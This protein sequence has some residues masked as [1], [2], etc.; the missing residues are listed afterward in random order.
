M[1]SVDESAVYIATTVQEEFWIAQILYP[2]A[3]NNVVAYI[4]IDTDVDID[5][6]G[7]ALRRVAAES[8]TLNINFREA[9]DQLCVISRR[10]TEWSPETIDLRSRTDAVAAA[11]RYLDDERTRLFDLQKD[12]LYR[13]TL[14]RIDTTRHFIALCFHHIVVDAA[15]L[16]LWVHRVFE[17]Y[18]SL[19]DGREI[20]PSGFVGI[21]EILDSRRRYEANEMAVDRDYWLAQV[22]G[23]HEFPGFPGTM[24]SGRL[25][26]TTHSMLLPVQSL[27]GVVELAD[28]WRVEPPFVLMAVTA[29]VLHR[30]SQQ[31]DLSLQVPLSNRRG[32]V[33]R[34]PCVVSTTVP[35]TVEVAGD[36]SL[37]SLTRDLRR[38]ILDAGRHARYGIAGI[39][40]DL[41]L[42]SHATNPFGPSVNV[43][44]LATSIPVGDG[45]ARLYPV[46]SGRSGEFSITFCY[47]PRSTSEM[48][49][50][51]EADAALYAR[52]DLITYTSLLRR[53]LD[54]VIG[55]PDVVVGALAVLDEA[56]RQLV[57]E[58]RTNTPEHPS[59]GPSTVDLIEHWSTAS[60]DSVAISFDSGSITY[61]EMAAR[62]D[63]LART[64]IGHGVGP[65]DVVAVALT[66]SPELIIV[67]LA[68]M[69]AGGAYLPVDLSSPRERIEFML[70]DAGP[71]VIV[72]DATSALL[73]PAGFEG[74][75]MRVDHADPLD[76]G[77]GNPGR[78]TRTPASRP[79]HLA[80][81]IYTSGSTG[82]PK[83]VAIT[84]ADLIGLL[85][86]TS[87]WARFGPE[88]VWIWCH[89][90]AFDFSV[91]E[92]WGALAYGGRLVVAPWEAVRSPQDLRRLIAAE[93]VTILNQTPSAFYSL[94][95]SEPRFTDELAALRMVVFGGEAL[96]PGRVSKWLNSSAADHVTL[97]N[98]YG[99]TESTVHVTHRVITA[100]DLLDEASPIGQPLSGMTAY[101]L[102][103]ALRPMPIGIPGELYVAGRQLARGYLG[104]A[105]LTAARFVANPFDES[106]GARLYRTGDVVRWTSTGELDYLGRSDDQVKLRGYRIELGEIE[107][108]LLAHPA[109]VQ[110]AVDVHRS[111]VN[112]EPRLIGYVRLHRGVDTVGGV[113]LRRFVG[114]R[115]PEFMVPA[116]VMVLDAFPLTVNGKLDRR[117]LPDPGFESS[118]EYRA[119][120]GDR[121][122]LLADVFGEVLGVSGV[123][124]D[125]SF[126]ELGGHSLLAT[127]LV[128][129]IRSVFGVEV[130]LPVVFDGPTVAQLVTR[131]DEAGPVRPALVRTV[132]PG[133]VPLSFAQQRL[134]F[135]HRFEGP[136]ATYNMPVALRLSGSVDLVALRAA[137]V[138]VVERHEALR[139][140]FIEVDGVAEQRVVD[141][142]QV[143]VPFSVSDADDL[144]AACV[145][146]AQY[147]FDL[148]REIPLRASVFRCSVDEYVL[149]LVVHHIAGDGWSV[150]PFFGDLTSAYAA[151]VLGDVADRVPLPVQY[152]DYTLWQRQLLGSAG[153]EASVLSQQLDYWRRELAGLPEQIALPT[154]RPRPRVAS[155]R[156]D[157]VP[158]RI[159]AETRESIERLA[160]R[161]NATVSMVLQS[162]LVT[163]LH[164]LGAGDD[165]AIGS[166]IAGRTDEALDDLVGFFV[167]TWVLRARVTPDLSFTE[168]VSQVRTKSLAAYSN[169][170]APFEL[171]VE[172]LNP[173]RSS[174]HPLFQIS[175][176]FQNTTQ[177]TVTLPGTIVTELEIP[178]NTARF[179]LAF[180]LREEDTSEPD[181][182]N[183]RDHAG[184]AGYIEYSTDLFDRVTVETIAARFARTVRN[185]A[186][187]PTIAVAAVD[188]LDQ[189]E[190]DL[191]L[192]RW[193][194]T[195][196]DVDHDTL[197]ELFER[198]VSASPNAVALLGAET[199]LTYRELDTRTN[200]LAYTLLGLGVGPE[201]VVAVALPRSPE[202]IIALVGIL[203]AGAAYL[204][205]DL[206]YPAERLDYILTDAAPVVVVTDSATSTQIPRQSS[207]LLVDQLIGDEK[208]RNLEDA[209][210]AH[211]PT[212]AN[213]AYVIYTS[214]TTGMPKGTVVTH[215]A[216]ANVTKQ[217]WQIGPGDRVL[218]HCAIAFD[219]SAYEI[220]PTLI[221]GATLVPGPAG[222]FEPTAI[223]KLIDNQQITH[224]FATCSALAALLDADDG[225]Q[226]GSLKRIDTGTEVL[227]PTTVGALHSTYPQTQLYNLYG[228]TETTVAITE[229]AL[230]EDDT[231][232]S[233]P[234][235]R[236]YG[237]CRAYVLDHRLAPTPI[238]VAGEL[239]LAGVQVARGYHQRPALTASRF[240]A[241]P[242]DP[243]GGRLYRTG[244]L[245]SWAPTGMLEYIGRR[246][247]QV[248]LRGYRIELGEIE[249]ALLAHPAVARAVVIA[250]DAH[251]IGYVLSSAEPAVGGVELRRF[252]GD[253]L[254]E[255]MV[256]AR[257]MVLDAFPLTVNG[258]L[259]R[260]ALPDP[261]F[262]S[263]VEYRAPRGD[264]ERLLADV[265]G[266]VLGVSGVG[267]DDSFFELGGH[268]LLATRL[269]SRIR[270]VFGVEVPL[271]VVFDGPTVAQLVTRLDEAG[272]VR[273]ALVRTV[274]PGSVPLSFAQQR[275]WFL[276]RFEGP[277]ATY[278]MP[279]ALRLSGSV[280]LVALRAAVV[281]V[282]ERHEALRTVFIEVD[283]VAEQRVVD[284]AQVDVPFSVSDAD[285]LDA[286]CVSAA[287]YRFDLSREIPLRASVFRCSVDEYVLV[288]VVHHIAGDGWSVAPFFGDLTSAYAARVLGDVADR[289]PLPVQYADY[290]LWQRQLLGSAGDEASVLSQQLDYWRRELAG[291]PEQI[292]L[293]TDRPRPRV[294]SH[295]GDI[296]PLRI[297]AETRESIERLARRANATVSMVLQSALVTLLHRLGAGDD[298]AI[299]SPIAGRTD[300]A[301]DDL[302]GFFVNTWVLRARVT[303]D[304]S[305]TELVSQVRTKSLAAYSNQDAPFE[306]LVEQLNPVRSSA[307]P[308]FQI[309]LAFQ[310]TTQPTVTLPGLDIDTMPIASTVARF[311]LLFDVLDSPAGEAWTGFIEYSTDLFEQSTVEGLA[312]RFIRVL[313]Q[314]ATAPN[315]A[316]GDVEILA[317]SE[318][319]QLLSRWNDTA[320]AIDDRATL[321][322]LIEDRVCRS[323]RSIAV[324]SEGVELS[325]RELNARADVC[326]RQLIHRGVTPDSVVAVAFPRSAALVVAMLA[327]LKAGGA[328]I[329]VDPDYPSERLAFILEDSDPV[330]LLTDSATAG[331]LPDT[332][333]EPL[334]LD[335]IDIHLDPGEPDDPTPGRTDVDLHPDNLAYLIYT[336]GSSGVPKA[337]AV[338]HR[339]ATSFVAA[340]ALDLQESLSGTTLA[341][342]SVAFDVS[343]LEIFGVL[344]AGGTIEVVADVLTLAHGRP[345]KGDVLSTVPSAWNAVL[346]SSADPRAETI[347][348]IGE[349]LTYDLVERTAALLPGATVVNGYGPT[350]TTVYVTSKAICGNH[351]PAE[352]P[353][354][355]GRPIANTRV[356]VLDTRLRPV[357][358]GVAG[359]LYIAGAQVARC[360]RGRA[361]L[362]AGRFVADP[363]DVSG[364]GRL[365]RTGD[366]VRWNLSGELEFIG[367]ADNQV[368][369]RGHRIELGEIETVL[370]THPGVD[371]AVVVARAIGVTDLDTQLIGY[372]VPRARG[373]DPD[374][375]QLRHYLSE[376][377]PKYMVPASI[378]ML[379]SLP[380]TP[381]G[382]LDRRALPAPVFHTTIEYQPPRDER[383]NS[384]TSL[385]EK[386]LDV[387]RVGIDDSFFDLGG[388]SLLVT[389]LVSRIR[390]EMGVEVPLPTIFES[391][392][393]RELAESLPTQQATH[394]PRLRKMDRE[395]RS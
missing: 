38:R 203:K 20:K 330:L 107:A 18:G 346:N 82:R 265:F 50:N 78:S 24:R 77:R 90:H 325:Y 185:A 154:D 275:L 251:L 109:V 227:P 84:H 284:I 240:V 274:R 145:S 169:Q 147:R 30:C 3:A 12:D 343:V 211:A 347:V 226:L 188:I 228:P 216:I 126:F 135:L 98:M 280:D 237:N 13:V 134:W 223:T 16:A 370:R 129:R 49:V 104:H 327:V 318:R 27:D 72:T 57:L 315:T 378:M 307:H 205:L 365:Y 285:D 111:V 220:W 335:T 336:S 373:G 361:A 125:D 53:F 48:A 208:S 241:N 181:A 297:D 393:V 356:F 310:N 328:Y 204:P 43:L 306:L 26:R 143:D 202:L 34:T 392:T 257:V 389:Q 192:N 119:P 221:S 127:R 289:V 6:L 4:D 225:T 264:R 235:G 379:E 86:S 377:L 272:P 55:D 128:S 288:L 231:P 63:A 94:I 68:V 178:T 115:L 195:T 249:A 394:R 99:L 350:E 372:A 139:T 65:D 92:M 149:V 383:E 380:L 133:S 329:P 44:P 138:D 326:A 37:Q 130:P 371:Q 22:E 54:Q 260:R 8:T 15:G 362:T 66:R 348:F 236:P 234:I 244:D 229:F 352:G 366:L 191:L 334:L 74:V 160:R 164:R 76:D 308:L 91:W 56:E 17:V 250:R 301:L 390:S 256:P 41:G 217:A 255:F 173:V 59:V 142:A 338:S 349:Q 85:R 242:F 33:G 276:H 268:S 386:I 357:P 333:H 193:S 5:L 155:H 388:H 337:V 42:S 39:K 267:V 36:T 224:L 88:D 299:G 259:D 121:E 304:L 9:D 189:G 122:R 252:V 170:D 291:L 35:V 23:H 358:A 81:V 254:P 376:K 215:A 384:L 186:A 31:Q 270:S 174:A 114:D 152:A 207:H 323:P 97:I 89:S 233:V 83:G 105:G 171:L 146:A 93:G 218:T 131:L 266:E 153:D 32:A 253:R 262:E 103:S 183:N 69:K 182:L 248:K 1:E 28:R 210:R 167:N 302:V 40:R 21:E 196:T 298:I 87:E 342:T 292:A 80:Y 222:S 360:Y 166:P 363:F 2:E 108:A 117:A 320:V 296:V 102:D 62:A 110:A 364:G 96:D 67:L 295:R 190:R 246:D 311:D 273:P 369:I 11:D 355:I 132:R 300:E 71:V 200:L 177:P 159:D 385:Y 180:H 206:S 47:D 374:P 278:N 58:N 106:P 19:L 70:A 322:S 124:V 283:G 387:P 316:L 29:A 7:A 162:A 331:L 212:P 238:G 341:T 194:G 319:E 197:I 312:A 165:I 184:L 375:A 179:D 137:V 46:G 382:K 247:L 156:G 45:Q 144:D 14:L 123:G 391:P 271:P 51:L 113:E 60:P 64:L 281:D 163:L 339:N 294:A 245:A 230:G 239:Y 150:A 282:V 344:C 263:S 187:D 219:A 73:I 324:V 176:A 317:A 314:V 118:V 313:Q 293:P 116:R 209:G 368:K 269:V 112:A 79:D 286:A 52:E 332:G 290:T 303:P 151:R 381:N 100:D 101:V 277:S 75:V 172:Q 354:P 309:S 359:E 351:V 136:S 261:G 95:D 161:A 148:S 10:N 201:S 157:I 353:M 214:G 199:H 321:V 158:L 287:Q 345:W 61:R 279:V 140:V 232:D 243:D 367:R 141:I 213:A 198:R 258:K 25:G 120:R 340:A 168:L 395:K 175:L 305:F